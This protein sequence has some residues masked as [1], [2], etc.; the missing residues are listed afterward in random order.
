MSSVIGARHPVGLYA[1]C[2]LAL[3]ERFA[4]SLLGS[5]LLLYL[6]ERLG[7]PLSTAA[8]WIGAFNALVYLSSVLGGIVADRVLGTRR[9]ILLGATLLAGGYVT[10][11]LDAARM[12]YSAAALLV[13]GHAL[14]KPSISAAVGKL[15]KPIDPRREQAYSLFYVVF[16]I[17]AAWGP[18]AGGFLRKHFGWFGAFSVAA[19]AMGIAILLGLFCYAWLIAQKGEGIP[20]Q[21]AEQA[22]RWPVAAMLGL[23]C[24]TLLFTAAYEQ[25]GMSLLLWARDCTRRA[26]LGHELP[27]SVWLSLPGA[28]VLAIQ[29][30]LRMVIAAW[31]RRSSEPTMVARIGA[32]MACGVS[33]YWVMF[34]AAWTH[35]AQRLPV[36]SVWLLVCFVALTLGEFLVYP[37]SMAL[38]TRIAPP[39]ASSIAMSLF[40]VSLAGG[41]WLAGEIASRWALW[42]HARLFLTL[43]G[44]PLSALIGL[45]F[46]R[47]AIERACA[48]SASHPA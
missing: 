26:L 8:R 42:S 40:L 28:L 6:N 43:A 45:A 36:S 27:A 32:G 4:A 37:L 13:A 29:P 23:L 31:A 30:L 22:Q 35:A 38:V 46:A 20:Q 25:S 3:F 15:Y 24:S 12:L 48:S 39:R 5:L 33:A 9:S 19:L 11:S 1:L 2:A 34:I 21:H 7:L 47:R 44:L 41:Q 14:F 18:I 10:L 17:G 16:N